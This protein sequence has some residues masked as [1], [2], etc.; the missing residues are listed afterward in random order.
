MYTE[1]EIGNIIKQLR[2]DMS[3][4]E[5][6]EKCN[7][8]HTTIDTLEKGYD[9][10]TKKPAQAKLTTLQ[11]IAD[12]CGVSLSYVTGESSTTIR[13]NELKVALFG[14]DTEVT[15][16]MWNEVKTFA[17][18]IKVKYKK[19]MRNKPMEFAARLRLAIKK[20]NTNAEEL[21]KK[22]ETPPFT[23]VNYILGKETPKLNSYTIHLL[24]TSLNVSESWL[25]GQYIVDLSDDDALKNV[26]F[27]D[28]SLF[29]VEKWK[30]ALDYLKIIDQDNLEEYDIKIPYEA[31]KSETNDRETYAKMDP[32]QSAKLY[33]A[34]EEQKDL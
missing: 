15:E 22:T 6:A 8:S 30:N 12:A 5:F 16:E 11:K 18:F 13:E 7:I 21:W 28:K 19:S 2:G 3:L 26:L 20:E 25:S 1:Q 31:A 33:N 14:G 24:A 32:E 17:D 29:T 23:L 27:A 4:R 9:F 34:E 10:R